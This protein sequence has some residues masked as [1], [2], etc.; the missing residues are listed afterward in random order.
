MVRFLGGCRLQYVFTTRGKWIG[1]SGTTEESE[2]I[3]LHLKCAWK[4]AVQE[5]LPYSEMGR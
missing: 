1:G 5:W 3:K 4:E 2:M